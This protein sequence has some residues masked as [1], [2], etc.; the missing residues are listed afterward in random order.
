MFK[1]TMN[2]P[3]SLIRISKFKVMKGTQKIKEYCKNEAIRPSTG[4][5]RSAPHET[6]QVK[7]FP[8]P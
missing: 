7:G 1:M 3:M 4:V 5:L 2:L 6:Y 8:S